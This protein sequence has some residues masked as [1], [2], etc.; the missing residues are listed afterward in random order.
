VI[1][2]IN[3]LADYYKVS[4][5]E[6]EET[7]N[8]RA[9]NRG[10]FL[11]R[12]YL[13]AVYRT[14]EKDSVSLNE[15]KLLN[16]FIV[17]NSSNP[18]LL[19]LL[20][21]ELSESVKCMIASA[22]LSR[23]MINLL[24]RHIEKFLARGG[25]LQIL[26][27]TMNCFNDPDDLIHLVKL[28]PNLELKVFYP[29]NE[30]VDFKKQPP[31]FHIKCFLFSKPDGH[32]S[33]VI[34]SSNMTG[35]G[36]LNNEEWNYYSNSEI[37]LAFEQCSS[38]T[39]FEKAREDFQDYWQQ[40]SVFLNNSFLEA[41]RKHFKKREI[42]RRL[43][44]ELEVDF[45]KSVKPSPRPAQKYALCELAQR[46]K[47][48]IKKA[49]VIAATGLGKTHLAA[50]DFEQSKLTKC[51]F[52]V[53]RAN[54]LGKAREVFREVLQNDS[55]GVLLTG[56]NNLEQ[57][58]AIAVSDC[59]VFAM[60]QTLSR[61]STLELFATNRFDYIV[62]DEFHHS[63]ARTYRSILRH[64]KS[65]FLLG[66]T[67]TP[68]RMDG[69]DV[70]EICDYEI[71]YE[72]RL[73]SAIDQGWL[74]PFQ[75]YAIYDET[76][77]SKIRWTGRGYDES[78]LESALENDTR[79][80]LIIKNLKSFLPSQGKIKALAFCSNKGHANYMSKK[81]SIAGLDSVA[82][83]GEATEAERKKAIARLQNE[84]DSLNVICS[85]DILGEGVDIP[86]VSH[87]LMLRPT[88]SFSVVL[89]QLGRGLRKTPGKEFL[90]VLDFIGNFRNS[91]ITPLIFNQQYSHNAD[92]ALK[93]TLD[94]QLPAG[95]Y[96]D[97]DKKV[98]KI[99][100]DDIKKTFAAKSRKQLLI[101]E[102][103][104]LQKLLGRSP[105]LLD[106]LANP[107][108]AEPK[109]FIKCFK[110]WLAVKEKAEDLTDFEKTVTGTI[111][112]DFLQH[113]EKELAPNKSYKMVVLKVLLKDTQ[114]RTS[115][116]LEWIAGQFRNYYLTHPSHQSDCSL[117]KKSN[118][119]N[120]IALK[121]FMK[122]VKDMPLAKLAG[123]GRKKTNV[124][125]YFELKKDQNNSFIICD[126]LKDWWNNPKFR[127]LI[128]DRVEYALAAYFYRKNKN[129]FANYDKKRPAE[130]QIL[131]QVENLNL[132]NELENISDNEEK[133]LELPFYVNIKVAAGRLSNTG[134]FED[135]SEK[136]KVQRNRLI[137]PERNQFVVKISGDSMDGGKEPIK[138]GELVVLEPIT[139]VSAGSLQGQ[140]IAVGYT[141]NS[142]NTAYAI[143]KVKKDSLGKYFL[144]S[145][146]KAYKDIPVNPEN[147]RTI[148]RFICKL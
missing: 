17:S 126:E 83:L 44:L 138:D 48:G 61:A 38:K 8:T 122:L 24:Q 80:G 66:L 25:Q 73:F 29:D 113:I 125:S 22:F 3:A 91:Y 40:Q 59:S 74:T 26:T 124:K 20:I 7:K 14:G 107:E 57:K 12:D 87:V 130:K 6:I 102:Y 76:D 103:T 140:I 127:K 88:E 11:N 72:A 96:V 51:L 148:A 58:K 139:P 34:G 75:Y 27:S 82:L 97:A 78:Q 79:A 70:L 52:V 68:E 99:W 116:P 63:E 84:S 95:C 147:F 121:K 135:S 71:A 53:H 54:I 5:E 133:L 33:L 18:T 37:N 21:Q 131:E 31:P 101:D 64:F 109:A 15:G 129:M 89:Q 141:D 47:Q 19:E 81:F 143:K 134:I 45:E 30:N 110:N 42:I 1:E 104:R 106:F 23:G 65:E 41:Y 85:V 94:F 60:V 67:A 62:F 118:G 112:A 144:V 128:Q 13:H 86:S 105:T 46:R 137:S 4:K 92:K 136:I 49:A 56:E 36:L 117:F 77:Y 120:N 146:N 93:A 119:N 39:V 114:R 123:H 28:F 69:R 132:Q 2:I 90:V 50:F 43:Q 35:G 100:H 16:P 108:A 142:G 98:Y 115:W 111:A 32:N 145:Q 10:R 9:L 55:F